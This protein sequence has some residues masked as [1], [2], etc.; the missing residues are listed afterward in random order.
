MEDSKRAILNLSG[1]ITGTLSLA[2]SH[3]I[4]LWRLPPLL[5]KFTHLY[6]DVSLDLHFMD[7]E[8]V[9]DLILQGNH[10]I[11]IATLAPAKNDR[12]HTQPVWQDNL[13]FVVSANHPL[14]DVTS[15]NLPDL[16]RYPAILPDLTTFTG[17]IVQN[18]FHSQKVDLNISMS[19]NYLETIK[20]LISIGLG[21]SVLPHSMIDTSMK[22]LTLENVNISRQLG[23]IHHIHRTLSNAGK[24][25]L[26]MLDTESVSHH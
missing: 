21:W 12:L 25:F 8:V 2:T 10:E 5:K 19:T 24:A 3:H 17:R 1:N 11:G 14:A 18:L 13:V 15:L 20:M 6:G 23:Y 4:G 16:A 7:S 26:T 22:T 9:H